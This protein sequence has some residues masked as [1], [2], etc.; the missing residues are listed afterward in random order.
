MGSAVQPDLTE[1]GS[2]ERPGFPSQL[3]TEMISFILLHQ[4]LA[5]QAVKVNPFTALEI[6]ECHLDLH[7]EVH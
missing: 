4:E 2:K 3:I 1:A 7:P 6:K 5:L